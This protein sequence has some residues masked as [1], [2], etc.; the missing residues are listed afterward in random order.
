[1]KLASF[2]KMVDV[3]GT[4]QPTGYFVQTG[5]N[6]LQ[7]KTKSFIELFIGVVIIAAIISLIYHGLM[8][9]TAGGD[10]NKVQKSIQGIIY[11]IVGLGI[12]LAAGLVINFA[13][14][15]LTK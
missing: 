9:I 7:T 5:S 11:S 10:S 3:V 12:A 8:F 1:M 13:V 14:E 4:V 15:F 6:T 2:L